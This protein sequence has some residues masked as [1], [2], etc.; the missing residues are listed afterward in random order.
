MNKIVIA[1]VLLIAAFV[2]GR[3]SVPKQVIKTEQTKVAVDI[4]KS[5][6]THTQTTTTTIKTPNGE[7]KT[8]TTTDTVTKSETSKKEDI[9]SS[10]SEQVT[11]KT[12]KLNIA[13]L[14][15]YDTAHLGVK[16]AIGVSVSKEVIGPLTIGLW[17][18]NTGIVG[19]SVGVNF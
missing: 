2:A 19:L 18:L 5:K 12:G 7:V 9:S 8:I 10:K 1:G 16:P 3:F 4:E 13:A 14:A 11:A 6:N 17:G 15:A